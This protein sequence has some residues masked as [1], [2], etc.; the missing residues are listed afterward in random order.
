[1]QAQIVSNVKKQIKTSHEST[2]DGES[3]E[4]EAEAGD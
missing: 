2:H 1:M 3:D 4:A